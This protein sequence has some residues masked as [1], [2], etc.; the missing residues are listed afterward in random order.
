MNNGYELVVDNFVVGGGTSSGIRI[1]LERDEIWL[2]FY[3]I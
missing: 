3:V 1:A 2:S